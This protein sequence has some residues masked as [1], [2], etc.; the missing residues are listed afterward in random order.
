M[1]QSR[2]QVHAASLLAAGGALW[3]M[4]LCAITDSLRT[5]YERA[6]AEGI[7]GK[8]AEAIEFLGHCPSCWGGAATFT[9]AAL[10]LLY[11]RTLENLSRRLARRPTAI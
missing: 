2:D 9:A 4:A 7:C 11:G 6:L 8:G 5:P 1:R 10:V 3:P